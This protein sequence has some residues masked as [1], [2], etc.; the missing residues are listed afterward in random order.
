MAQELTDLVDVATAPLRPLDLPEASRK[1]DG[2]SLTDMVRQP[3]L[4]AGPAAPAARTDVIAVGGPALRHQSLI[5]TVRLPDTPGVRRPAIRSR[6]PT[7]SPSR[8][9]VWAIT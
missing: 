7:T 4:L 5:R 9:R 8:E 1:L 2:G 6:T 3:L